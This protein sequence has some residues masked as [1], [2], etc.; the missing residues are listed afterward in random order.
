MRVC[1]LLTPSLNGTDYTPNKR[2]PD[3]NFNSYLGA[4]DFFVEH[5]LFPL[6]I[7]RPRITDERT[8]DRYGEVTGKVRWTLP[9]IGCFEQIVK[10]KTV[11]T[12]PVF[13]D[14]ESFYAS[15][16]GVWMANRW[17]RKWEG[18]C[19]NLKRQWESSQENENQMFTVGISILVNGPKPPNYW[20]E[21]REPYEE[22]LER[23]PQGYERV[24]NVLEPSSRKE[25]GRFFKVA[26]PMFIVPTIVNR[27]PSY[28]SAGGRFHN[29]LPLKNDGLA[30]DMISNFADLKGKTL[31][32]PKNLKSGPKM[33][34]MTKEQETMAVREWLME[35]F[36]VYQYTIFPVEMKQHEWLGNPNV[37]NSS[38]HKILIGLGRPDYLGIGGVER[39]DAWNE[40]SADVLT[41]YLSASMGVLAENVQR[42]NND[43]VFSL[44]WPLSDTGIL[45]SEDVGKFGYLTKTSTYDS[46]CIPPVL[47][48]NDLKDGYEL[49]RFWE[50]RDMGYLNF[51]FL[52]FM[53]Y[54]VWD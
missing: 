41:S 40:L 43:D 34:K 46:M 23:P 30:S 16:M 27:T 48:V 49:E 42:V 36:S 10:G 39:A 54:T 22:E 25:V 52:T 38:A 47:R 7:S 21:G 19:E 26:Y 44:N 50:K 20:Y 29:I 33:K 5:S 18:I 35:Q 8:E 17:G 32:T 1:V 6:A 15:S 28:Y 51:G 4:Y 12:M 13:S 14:L 2:R 53:S 31:E 24:G 9:V 3:D 11:W 37:R 45:G